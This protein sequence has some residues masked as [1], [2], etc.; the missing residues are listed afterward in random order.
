MKKIEFEEITEEEL[1]IEYTADCS[2]GRSECCTRVCTRDNVV[3][4]AEDW[5]KFLE[6]ESG[7][8][9]Y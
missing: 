1:F 3:A 9:Q 4:T 6:V 7:V 2:G 8:I 5:G